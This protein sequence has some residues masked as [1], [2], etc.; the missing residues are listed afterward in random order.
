[1]RITIALALALI[2]ERE[3]E[4]EKERVTRGLDDPVLVGLGGIAMPLAIGETLHHLRS[5]S[6]ST[7]CVCVARVFRGS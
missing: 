6:A 7:F 4:R 2:R 3:R 5:T 1:M